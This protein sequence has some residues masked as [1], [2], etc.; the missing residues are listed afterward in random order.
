MAKLENSDGDKES[1]VNPRYVL[2]KQ[3]GCQKYH[4]RIISRGPGTGTGLDW[5]FCSYS[6]PCTAGHGDCDSDSQCA[7]S[8]QC[9]RDNCK[10]FNP[11]AQVM[12]DCCIGVAG[13]RDC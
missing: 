10:D 5:S 7:G 9:G 11:A 12:A 13:G 3:R 2:T 8:L 6:S 1:S 4:K